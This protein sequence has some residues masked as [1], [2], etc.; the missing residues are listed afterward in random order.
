M[1]LPSDGSCHERYKKS[2]KSYL[3]V[4]T[5]FAYN[6]GTNPDFLTIEQIRSLIIERRPWIFSYLGIALFSSKCL[7]DVWSTF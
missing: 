4:E 7:L 2:K 1:I 5:G 3:P 6:S